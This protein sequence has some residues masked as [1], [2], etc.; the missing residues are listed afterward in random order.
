[1]EPETIVSITR[2]FPF[3]SGAFESKLFRKF[4]PQKFGIGDYELGTDLNLPQR[5]VNAF[6][7]SN[8]K[9]VKGAVQPITVPTLELEVDAFYRLIQDSSVVFEDEP[10]PDDRRYSIEVQS[11]KEVSL[12]AI[13]INRTDRKRMK[14]RKTP[15]VLVGAKVRAVILPRDILDDPK[16]RATVTKTWGAQLVPY[17]YARLQSPLVVH[18]AVWQ[19]ASDYLQTERFL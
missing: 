9:Y 12:R 11:N 2:I 1:M 16:I 14:R 10:F 19:V 6:F 5:I 3:D 7:G 13:K 18:G 8:E 4:I 17:H 15:P